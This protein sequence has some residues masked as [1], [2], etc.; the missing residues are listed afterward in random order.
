MAAP[1]HAAAVARVTVRTIY[2]WVE[3]EKVHFTESHDGSVS[4]CLRSCLVRSQL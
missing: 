3:E 4:V 2:R 1:E